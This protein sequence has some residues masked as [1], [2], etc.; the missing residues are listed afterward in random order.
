MR[1][2]RVALAAS[3]RSP[4]TPLP[5]CDRPSDSHHRTRVC[6]IHAVEHSSVSTTITPGPSEAKSAVRGR[7][8]NA[9]NQRHNFLL[10]PTG[11]HPQRDSWLLLA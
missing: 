1:G 10:P 8:A 3:H 4:S 5:V 7:T 11:Y 2:R 6:A 9:K